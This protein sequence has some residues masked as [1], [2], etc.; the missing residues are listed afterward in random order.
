MS[1]DVDTLLAALPGFPVLAG[2]RLRLRAPRE[3]DIDDVFALFSDPRVMRYWSSAPMRSR[4]Q[5][6]ARIGEILDLFAR[7][8]MLN[9]L[10]ADGRDDRAI[11]SCTLFQFDARHRRAEVG[12]A[13]RSGRWGQGLASEAVA[14][15][16]DWGFDSLALHRIE[17]DVD[18]GNDASRQLLL[19]LG[20]AREGLL[21]ERYFVGDAAGDSE[22][23]GLLAR[24]WRERRREPPATHARPV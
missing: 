24:E 9:W 13:L 5:A 22:M 20:F 3:D 2:Q 1:R 21:R 12:F 15:A 10:I 17:A 4:L 14:L 23:F 18:P 7:R 16:L 6:E 11:G 19:R 8:E